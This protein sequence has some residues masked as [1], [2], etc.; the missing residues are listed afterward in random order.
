MTNEPRAGNGLD[1]ETLAA[2]IDKRLPPDEHSGVE[3]KLAADPDSYELLVELIHANEALKD[4]LPLDQTE[5]EPSGDE[6]PPARTGAVVPL[7]PKPARPRMW[8]IAS[9]VLAVA[10]V[11]VLVVRVQPDLL[12]RLR[13]G[14]AVDPQLAKLVAVV[15]EERYIEAR[16]TGGFKYG[17]LRSVTRGP[18]DL[19]RENLELLAVQVET[20]RAVASGRSAERLHVLGV[21]QIL[22]GRLDDGIATL[23]EAARLAPAS[24]AILIDLSAGYLARGSAPADV[25]RALDLAEHAMRLEPDSLEALY[26]RAL[27]AERLRLPAA[28][29]YWR[30]AAALTPES[31]WRD[32]ARRRLTSLNPVP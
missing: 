20:E 6:A 1:P 15:G 31:G 25:Q 17:P 7:A 30:E 4:E 13:G 32:E 21:S 12:Q 14:D 2:Y 9:G 3:A 8:A 28:I 16:L 22:T 5:P 27:A 19:S 29:T 10:A 24:S 18:A 23:D 11:L 26:N